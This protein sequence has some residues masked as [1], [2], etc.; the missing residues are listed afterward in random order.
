M[1]NRSK[2]CQTCPRKL[3][4][5]PD[6]PCPLAIERI[7]SSRNDGKESSVGCPWAIKSADHKFCFWVL[8]DEL[9]DSPM[10]DREICDMLGITQQQLT[11]SFTSAV[12]KLESAKDTDEV[13]ELRDAITE[14]LA[15]RPV[16]QTI[17]Y[18][19]QFGDPEVATEKKN[20]ANEP[21]SVEQRLLHDRSMPIHRSGKRRDLYGLSNKKVGE[22]QKDKRK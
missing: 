7:E 22:R 5:L 14:R 2:F 19:E 16:D 20:T 9:Q 18:P 1:S 4:R 13:R 3:E 11:Q 6:Q 21:E 10:P 17:Y 8:A 15:D 12:A